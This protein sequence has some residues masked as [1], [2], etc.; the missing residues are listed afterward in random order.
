MHIQIAS[1]RQLM[2]YQPLQQG[3]ALIQVLLLTAILSMMALH[4]TLSSRQQVIIATDLQNKIEAEVQ[5][6][7]LESKVLFALL[8]LPRDEQDNSERQDSVIG[9]SWNFFGKP[10]KVANNATVSF[11]D[12]NGLLSVYGTAYS[13]PLERLLLQFGQSSQQAKNIISNLHHWQGLDKRSV[14]RT[15]NDQVRGDYLANVAELKLI[16]GID[17]II[18]EK[19]APVVTTLQNVLFNPMTAPLPVL[20]VFMSADI[21]QEIERLRQQGLLTK[22]RFSELTQIVEDDTIT[23]APG[24][25]Q[26][27]NINIQVGDSIVTRHMIV[28]IRPEN[29]IP[30][31]W[32]Q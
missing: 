5:M 20:K 24:R 32:F 10:F 7:T 2:P 29:Q 23:F 21:A 6:R 19:L 16:A 12:I 9:R 26:F 31:V 22:Q 1:A 28:Y 25:R 15:E 27:I 14:N 13:A 4:F 11:Q 18:Y 17:D 3:I 8:T 30:L